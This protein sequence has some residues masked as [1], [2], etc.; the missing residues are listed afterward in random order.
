MEKNVKQFYLSLLIVAMSLGT[1]WAIRGQFGHEHGAAWAGSIGSL[2]VLLVVKRKDW[3]RKA[4]SVVLAGAFGWGL[5][6]MMSYGQVVGYG[7]GSDWPNVVYGLAMLFIIGGLYGFLGGGL[8]G[9]GLS[10]TKKYPVKWPKLIVEMT[11][12]AI[13]FYF[14]IIEQFGWKMTPPRSELWAACLGMAS[15]LAWNITRGKNKAALR[16]AIFSSLGAGFG[17]AFGNFL[18]VI[19]QVSQIHFNFWN[20]ME[21]SLGFFGGLGLA[22]GT[23][24]TEWEKE[25]STPSENQNFQLVFLVLLIPFVMWQQNF[26]LARIES[27][28]TKL[29]ASN[30]VV[31]N[32]WV[33]WGALLFILIG[34][35]YW[36]FKFRSCKNMSFRDIKAF[37]FGHWALYIALSYMITGAFVSIYRLE[38]YL[39]L[40][41][42][43][44]VLLVIKKVKP[45]FTA[46]STSLYSVSKYLAC[47][48][49]FISILA[50]LAVQSHGELK[51]ARKRF[52]DELPTESVKKVVVP[53]DSSSLKK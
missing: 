43:V 50:Y 9:L 19:G 46:L 20:V 49:A 22:Y 18:Q 31:F 14:F 37:F 33:Q 27:T 12:G 41:N 52:G 3:L 25:E 24:T 44:I 47:I 51:G 8:F 36:I 21:Y 10:D 48:A 6:G 16:V 13:I 17:F 5:G 15:A 1:A 35:G 29:V 39:Y 34:G 40:L 30:Y 11:I 2:A 26:E 42:L 4:F 38:Q 7:R 53:K 28:F 45:Q 23:L 32:Q